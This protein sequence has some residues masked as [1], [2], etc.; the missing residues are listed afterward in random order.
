[1]AQLGETGLV[2]V[3]NRLVN[4]LDGIILLSLQDA[5][6]KEE[7]EKGEIAHSRECL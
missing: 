3:L 5:G 2:F 1:V 6:K 4:F 7:K